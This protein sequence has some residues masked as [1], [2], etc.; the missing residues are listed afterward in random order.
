MIQA[1]ARIGL[2]LNHTLDLLCQVMSRNVYKVSMCGQGL[3]HDNI[4]FGWVLFSVIILLYF[5]YMSHFL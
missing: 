4:M 2:T 5:I 3:V 1:I